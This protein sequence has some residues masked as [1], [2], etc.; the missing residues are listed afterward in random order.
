M[1]CAARKR[2]DTGETREDSEPVRAL[3]RPD[4]P[5]GPHRELVD[6]LHTLHHRAGWPS[7]RHLA[8]DTGVSHTTVS[9]TF[10]S[11]ALPRWGTLELLVEAMSG[12]VPCFHEL[13]LA[14]SK[15]PDPHDLPVQLIAGRHDELSAVRRHFESRSGLLLVTG[16]AG[17][18]K[19]TLVS[20]AAGSV[21]TF[22]AV[23]HCLQLSKE[24]PLL[25]VI[26]ILRF[27]LEVDDGHW[28][29][30][31][32]A[33]CPAYV[34]TSLGRLVPELDT[35]QTSSPPDDPWGQEKLFAA[36]TSVLGGLAT[37]RPLALHIEDCHWADRSTLDLLTHMASSPPQLPL[38][39][40]W[41]SA[42]P[43]VSSSHTEWLSRARWT[44][45]VPALDLR[46]LTVEETAQQ[47]RLLRGS[48]ADVDVV[49]RIQARGGGLPL[50]T[51][52]LAS[53]ADDV[54][55]PQQLA[56]LLDRRIGDL[57][58]HAW[59]VARV[60]GLAQRRVGPELLTAAS[61]LDSDEAADALRVLAS[62]GL[63]KGNTGGDAEL[64][65]PLFDEAI[66]RRLLPGEGAQVHA[67]LAQ[68]LTEEPGIEP[69]EV[70]DHWQAAN[71]PD[72]EA[73]PR[74]SAATRA[75][76][77]F[78]YREALDAWLRV[79]ELLD[80]G[81][82]PDDVELWEV[83]RKA[84]KAAIK[85]GDF[86]TGWSLARRG[87]ALHLP[88][89]QRAVVLWL[90]AVLLD[91]EGK[92]EEC[93]AHL[94]AASQLLE[95]LPPSPE[96]GR[97]LGHRS[98]FFMQYGRYE[99]ARAETLHAL[100][101]FGTPEC[102]GWGGSWLSDV[103]WLTGIA[104]D[105]D[106]ALAIA[107]DALA[108]ERS[109]PDPRADI[110]VA[111]V[112]TSLMLLAGLPPAEIEE[113]ARDVLVLAEASNLTQSNAGVLLRTNLCVAHLRAGDLPAAREPL[114]AVT[115]TRPEFN[116]AEAHLLLAQVELLEGQAQGAL[117]RCH[118]ANALLRR[119]NQNWAETVQGL[120]EIE[121]WAGHVDAALN[122]VQEALEV[123]LPTHDFNVAPLLCLWA[124]SLADSLDASS[125]TTTQRWIASGQLHDLL[126]RAGTD[127]FDEASFD[128]AVPAMSREWRAEIARITGTAS[129]DQ[130]IHA[131]TAWDRLSRVHDAAYCRWR[132]A[133]V[134]RLVGQGTL[135]TRLLR[136][137]ASDARSH[138]PLTEAIT[139][140]GRGG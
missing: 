30:E 36:V 17:I 29:M 44:T 42:D 52:Q 64:A 43:D 50:Y 39:L 129:V 31:G 112:A 9:K 99:E 37:A 12:D 134:A 4:V 76:D 126:A 93:L 79:V 132:A 46:T 33:D 104:G 26:E 10:S 3:P 87:Q 131:A 133:Q 117:Q 140:T 94:D 48:S 75:G 70:A 85:A 8:A 138:A 130:W 125:A 98:N 54:E 22:V 59:R 116:T 69:A 119:R 13:W 139:A 58:G 41:R 115:R 111:V 65:H 49:E 20:A 32:L 101:V 96:L 88:D 35:T 90:V 123:S 128:A 86:D 105:V 113:L 102:L 40:T 19:T 103:I 106:H 57:N 92:A 84:L 73:S 121:L 25:P 51:A 55:L 72:L 1:P 16:E 45:G 91:L 108:L 77:R 2:V 74:V 60:L 38:V 78:A 95:A 107:R 14:A 135:A 62:R 67:R 81:P 63:L 110:D 7:L 124:R 89:R 118:A 80:A 47:I 83:L 53:A 114:R 127:P 6:A 61:G 97:L 71:R 11:Q 82:T 15:P 27:L 34:R 24:V 23:G 66:R 68:S 18:G 120:I 5:P 122:L 28:M 109:E 56:D 136:R 100:E 21:D 137:A